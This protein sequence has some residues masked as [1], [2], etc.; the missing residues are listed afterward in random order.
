LILAVLD[1]SRRHVVRAA[2]AADVVERRGLGDP[3]AG[4]SD[5]DREL[6]LRVHVSRF[7]RQDDRLA[8]P[9]QRIREL[10]E[11]EGSLGRRVTELRRMLRVVSANANDFHS[12]ILTI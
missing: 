9:D 6:G 1:V 12:V 8:G 11:D 2:V 5:L 4:D 7:K 3:P 10:A